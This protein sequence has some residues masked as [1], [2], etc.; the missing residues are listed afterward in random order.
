M[1]Q[2][3]GEGGVNCFSPTMM[4]DGVVR[5]EFRGEDNDSDE[6]RVLKSGQ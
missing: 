6:V 3:E 4:N 2:I 1:D 5:P